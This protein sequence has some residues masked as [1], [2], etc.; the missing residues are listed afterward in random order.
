MEINGV[1]PPVPAKS[2]PRLSNRFL[3][4]NGVFTPPQHAP[5]RTPAVQ[6]QSAATVLASSLV[7]Y[8]QPV[9]TP[10]LTPTPVPQPT[11]AI[12]RQPRTSADNTNAG[13]TV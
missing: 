1:E 4:I 7:S 6:A 9:P 13:S 3:E 2:S 5:A 8:Q 11:G 12:L 10:E